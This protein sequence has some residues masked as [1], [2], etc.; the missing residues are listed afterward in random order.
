[1]KLRT[2]EELFKNLCST[3]ETLSKDCSRIDIIF[4]LYLQNSVKEQERNRRGN[5][6]I[7][8]TIITS[9]KQVL[10]VDT[11]DF[12]GSSDNKMQLQQAFIEWMKETYH[13]SKQMFLGGANKENVHHFTRW[14]FSDLEELWVLK[15]NKTEYT[16]T[17]IHILVSHYDLEVIDVLPAVHALTGNSFSF[18]FWKINFVKYFAQKVNEINE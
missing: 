7:T 6:K 15:G 10:P 11:D 4:D 14:Q 18:Q 13:G 9:V 17:P 16:A 2:Y 3:F 1:M 5:D 12:W 8:E